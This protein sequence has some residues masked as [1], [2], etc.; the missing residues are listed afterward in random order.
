MQ[1]YTTAGVAHRLNRSPRTVRD[2]IMDGCPT[3]DGHRVRLGAI[4]IGR[5]WA[6]SDE[7]LVLFL[8]RIRPQP[9]GGRP[10][11]MQEAD[12]KASPDTSSKE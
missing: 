7:D 12:P 3:M 5:S 4:K 6:V 10:D 9:E 1:H 8:H 11:P 2:W